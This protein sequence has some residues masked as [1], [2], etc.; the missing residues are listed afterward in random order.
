MSNRARQIFKKLGRRV[1]VLVYDMRKEGATTL[2]VQRK[3]NELVK[4]FKIG[5]RLRVWFKEEIIKTTAA[6]R[7]K[8]E[9]DY[10]WVTEHSANPAESA[11]MAE[12]YLNFEKRTKDIDK[13]IA[14]E[15]ASIIRENGTIGELKDRLIHKYNVSAHHAATEANTNIAAAE[16]TAFFEFAEEA[17]V[18][19][20]KY[21]GPSAERSFC[22]NHLNK[23]YT[24]EEVKDM[25]NDEGQSALRYGGGHNCRHGWDA[26]I[27]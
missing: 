14:K 3:V 12:V 9:N 27:D 11:A 5:P 2:E 20:L 1:A 4:S 25:K 8:A 16:R 23:E 21:T 13:N 6:A 10:T 19:K 26:V 24:L 17:D 22:K 7:L 15:T 18:E